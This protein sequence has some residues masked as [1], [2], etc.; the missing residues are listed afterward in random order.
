[1]RVGRCN[2][3]V[4]AELCVSVRDWLHDTAVPVRMPRTVVVRVLFELGDA[5]DNAARIHALV[6][7]RETRNALDLHLEQEVH[8]EPR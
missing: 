7:A 6:L 1:M 5:L 2:P 8:V 3:T 4:S